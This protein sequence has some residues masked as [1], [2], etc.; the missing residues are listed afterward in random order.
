[1]DDET[2]EK[3]K[4]DIEAWQYIKEYP[5]EWFGFKLTY[6]MQVVGDCFNIFYYANEAKRR[7][8]TLYY[9]HETKEYKVKTTVGLTEF[10]NYEFISEN[11]KEAEEKLKSRFERF[12]K[13]LAIFNKEDLSVIVLEKKILEWQYVD[14]LP[15]TIEGFTL[16][17]KPSETFKGINGSYIVFDYSDFESES[18]FII[19]Y[20]VFRDEFFGEAK[21]RNIPEMNYTFDSHELKELEE[22][23]DEHLIPRLKELRTKLSK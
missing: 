10:C 16:F 15:K 8:M 9:H 12:L 18:N 14:E 5:E 2:L 6:E 20:N 21:I 1:M 23:L 17:S 13:S 4:K 7:K 11:I 22:K 19:F 3:I